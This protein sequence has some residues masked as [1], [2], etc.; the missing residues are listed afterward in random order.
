MNINEL[1]AVGSSL[2]GGFYAGLFQIGA[3]KFAL[4]VAPKAEGQRNDIAWGEPGKKINAKSPIDGLANTNAM[5]AEGYELGKWARALTI[6]GFNDWYLPS[7]DELE[8]CYRNLKPATEENFCGYRDGDN[9]NSI[10]PVDIYEEEI[11]AQTS[12]ELFRDGNAEAFDE[13]WYW[14]S[15]QYSAVY[16]YVQTFADGLQHDGH[17]VNGYRARAVRRL[18]VI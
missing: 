14:T 16:A 2:E 18:L 15:T 6:A 3:E 4:I 5:A 8:I 1:P 7:R 12:V 11:P 17:K 13:R 10:P 9:S